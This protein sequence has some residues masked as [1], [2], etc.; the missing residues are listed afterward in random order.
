MTG[1]EE[2]EG[3]GD[4]VYGEEPAPSQDQ[5]TGGDVRPINEEELNAWPNAD[6]LHLYYWPHVKDSEPFPY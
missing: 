4:V 2:E 5:V 3:V 6:D 1:D